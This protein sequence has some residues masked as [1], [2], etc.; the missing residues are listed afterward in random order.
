M[1]PK[2][3]Y[4]RLMITG[5]R[6]LKTWQCESLLNKRGAFV[7]LENFRENLAK[8]IAIQVQN[9][10]LQ[11][12]YEIKSFPINYGHRLSLLVLSSTAG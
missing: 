5:L 6:R 8:A 9:T 2:L 1:S 11:R 7:F 3:L 12:S 10:L 4:V